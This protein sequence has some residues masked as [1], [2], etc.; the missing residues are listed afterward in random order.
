MLKRKFT[1]A[2]TKLMDSE[3]ELEHP[4]GK[5]NVEFRADGFNHFVCNDFP[6]HSHWRLD[7]DDQA[8]PLLYIN[9]GKF[10][11]YE[12]TIAADGESMTGSA[13]GKPDNW[14]KMKRLRTLGNVAEAHVH[15]H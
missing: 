12:L 15:D 13:K 14:R 1:V 11:E 7:N 8:T 5:F 9:W 3:W 10:G 2:E 4:G 6:A